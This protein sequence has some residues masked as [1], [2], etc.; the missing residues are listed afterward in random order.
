MFCASSA[1][2]ATTIFELCDGCA[3]S[4]P[5]S[6]AVAMPRAEV[7]GHP[8]A[9]AR[10]QAVDGHA[11]AGELLRGDHRQ[12]GDARLGGAVVA[13]ADVAEQARRARRVDDPAADRL[14][15]LGAVAPVGGGVVQRTERAL[16]VDVDDRVP[17]LL[18]HVDDHPVAQ[19]PGVVDEDVEL[20]EVVDRLL[21]QLARGGEVGDVG[22]VDDRL[23]PEC[24][25]LP[26]D[27]VGR[28]LVGARPVALRAE[29]VDDDLRA[30][31]RQMKR[32]L[33][34]DPAPSA[35]DD[36]NLPVQES[37]PFSCSL[38]CLTGRNLQVG[39][40]S[41]LLVMLRRDGAP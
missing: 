35:G 30:L 23:A 34:T 17:L 20:A 32:V 9:G 15:R 4:G 37:H 19:D 18:G 13:L 27:V 11:V 22:A 21:D 10:R 40:W 3:R 14:A 39:T 38:R 31:T 2:S 33:A 8:R 7:L 6:G 25:D 1:H 5:S 16:E 41:D 24:L 29:V 12:A 28:T 36:R 26:H